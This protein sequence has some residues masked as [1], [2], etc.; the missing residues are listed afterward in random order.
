MAG[1]ENMCYFVLVHSPIDLSGTIH[2]KEIISPTFCIAKRADSWLDAPR[3]GQTCQKP[4][5]GWILPSRDDAAK[6][7]LTGELE[8]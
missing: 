7:D 4:V 8:T 1:A 6:T 2:T 3:P 5:K